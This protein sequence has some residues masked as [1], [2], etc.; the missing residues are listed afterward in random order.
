VKG[1]LHRGSP[2]VFLKGNVEDKSKI[3]ELNVS[4][5]YQELTILGTTW[6]Q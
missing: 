1:K 2:Y 4:L 3:T 6:G 5:L